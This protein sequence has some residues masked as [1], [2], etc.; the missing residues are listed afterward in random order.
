MS[1]RRTTICA[2]ALLAWLAAGVSPVPASGPLYVTG[3]D[4]TFPGRA[5]HWTLNPIPYKTDLGSLG[6]Q[7]NAQAN[8][9]VSDAFQV[10]QSVST[11]N[12]SFQNPGQLSTDVT[13]ANIRDFQNAIGGCNDATQ[14]TN[15]IIYDLDGSAVAEYLGAANR[16]LVLGFAGPLCLDTVAGVYTRGWAV[17]NGWFI[18]GSS[19]PPGPDNHKQVS[20][21]TFKAV[22]I[23]EF[24][25]L[26]GLD[27]SQINLDCLD[28]KNACVNDGSI[29]GVPTMFPVLL[30][31]SQGTPR[32]DDTAGL[33]ALY[34]A[35]DGSFTSTKGRIQGHVFFSDGA[36]PA[37][38]YN[39]IA[40]QVGHSRSIAASCVSGF[41]FTAAAG[42]TLVPSGGDTESP[43]G[44]RDHDLIGF[45]DIPGLPPGTYTVEVE[46]INNSGDHPFIGGSSVGPIGADSPVG[47]GFQFKMP[48]TA[49][50]LTVTVTANNTE[51]GKDLIFDGTPPRYDAWED[52]P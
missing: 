49:A 23:H 18:D 20:L 34:P 21:D 41:R 48:W 44:S 22:F 10:W 52:G 40:R 30:D 2:L 35:A 32:T 36:T 50:Q 15:S 6:T 8:T 9:L 24:G 4:A 43:F 17:M 45:Y 25:H 31:V 37:Q 1:L 12:I 27:H 29:V 13:A 28:N 26:I 33:S 51:V 42:N 46:A 38:G 19:L 7:T 16:N 14:P 11:A 39:V 5:Y 47:L 3:P